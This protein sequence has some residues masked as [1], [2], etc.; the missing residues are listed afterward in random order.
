LSGPRHEEKNS[1]LVSVVLTLE[2]SVDLPE[3]V[4][5]TSA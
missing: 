2:H 4:S 5:S 3:V 1:D